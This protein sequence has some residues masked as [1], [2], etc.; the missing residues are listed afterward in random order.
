[1]TTM[2]ETAVPTDVDVVIALCEQRY[3]AR[4]G[5]ELDNS[6]NT[7]LLNYKKFLLW[8]CNNKNNTAMALTTEESTAG[9][10]YSTQHN[11]DMF[12][13][14]YVPENINGKMCNA[15]RYFYAIQW[16]RSYLEKPEGPHLVVSPIIDT[17][18]KKQQSLSLAR[19][20]E[21]FAG[22]DP[23]KG[24][25]GIMPIDDTLKLVTY[26]WEH[27]ADYADILFCFTWGTNAGVRGQSARAFHLSDLNLSYGYGPER[28][29]PRNRTL[30]LILR[31][32]I[33]HKEKHT[34]DKQVGVHR[35]RD[36]RQCAVFATGALLIKLL[37]R[38]GD[39][40]QFTQPNKKQDPAW[41]RLDI[42]NFNCLNEQSDSMRDVYAKTGVNPNCKITHH[43]TQ[44]VLVGGSN[45]LDRR[46]I[47]TYTKH[48][49]DRLDDSYMP[50][51]EKKALKVMAGFDM[52]SIIR[53]FFSL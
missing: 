8:Y 29:P 27:R 37:R 10:V 40:I 22:V 49:I 24:L 5:A 11:T 13:C 46:Q 42:S 23:H 16:F 25:R 32:G 41:W 35:H 15:K 50:D 51:C 38:V 36:Y 1:M 21:T 39:T 2:A 17:A 48:V 47:S 7:Y 26:M 20:A 44:A 28:A 3:N 19:S 12:Y 53:S 30:L 34:T 14:H 31:R 4:P 6:K 9:T 43:R 18:L 33:P 52:V 45:G